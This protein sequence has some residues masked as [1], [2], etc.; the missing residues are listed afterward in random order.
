MIMK[1]NYYLVLWL[2]AFLTGSINVAYAQSGT[3]SVA[4]FEDLQLEPESFWFYNPNENPGSF[5]SGSFTF[6][7]GWSEYDGFIYW[8]AF[9]YSNM[10]LGIDDMHDYNAQYGNTAGQGANGSST[11]AVAFY[12]SYHPPFIDLDNPAVVS[13]VYLNNNLY[14]YSSM[15][16]GDY[17]AGGPFE[18]GDYFKVIFTPASD[19]AAVLPKVECYLADYRSENPTDHYII[20]DWTWFDLSSLGEVAALT[21]SFEGSRTGDWGLNT[22]AYLCMDN[23]GASDP[24]SIPVVANKP[25]SQ[26]YT[27]PE[28]IV[29]ETKLNNYRLRV[30]SVDGKLVYNNTGSGNSKISISSWTKGIY[31]IEII[32]PEGKET[33][34]IIK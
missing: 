24:T 15:I 10:T 28:H 4:T 14:A 27:I 1:K 26:I 22:P 21:F 9:A 6:N 2:T 13:G 30:Y 18:Q 19:E 34:K 16:N 17:Y 3:L 33:K 8:D 5:K 20:T 31:M 32:S 25:I 7:N 29:I 11:F 23:L 12:S